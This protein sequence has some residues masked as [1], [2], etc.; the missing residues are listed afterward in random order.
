MRA[1]ITVELSSTTPETT[2][3]YTLPQ[4]ASVA[5][6]KE[7]EA[8]KARLLGLNGV[9]NLLSRDASHATLCCL[10]FLLFSSVRL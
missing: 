7:S 2:V 8:P 3:E 9:P 10:C 6:Q 1:P 4:A 5:E